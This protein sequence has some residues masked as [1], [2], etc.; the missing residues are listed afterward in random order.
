MIEVT[1]H[2]GDW[3]MVPDA[4]SAMVAARELWE[5]AERSPG[6]PS[7]HFEVRDREGKLVFQ[8]TVCDRKEL[9]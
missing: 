4:E 5:D 8:Q 9:G 1:A 2:N 7:I 3:T 6:R